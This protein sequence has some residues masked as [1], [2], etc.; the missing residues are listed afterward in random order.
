MLKNCCLLEI[1]WITSAQPLEKVGHLLSFFG[2]W[3]LHLDGSGHFYHSN[4][5]GFPVEGA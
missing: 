5:L 2:K 1:V 4:L 3:F